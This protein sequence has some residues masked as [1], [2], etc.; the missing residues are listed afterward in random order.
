METIASQASLSVESSRQQYC[1]RQ[2]FPSLG[3][4]PHPGIEPGS[5]ALQVYSFLSEPPG[6][7]SYMH[8]SSRP[9]EG[10][11]LNREICPGEEE[12]NG[13]LGGR[14]TIGYKRVRPP[15]PHLLKILSPPQA[16][17]FPIPSIPGSS[18]STYSNLLCQH[19]S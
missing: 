14:N 8:A 16:P 5:P 1:S 11:Y 17:F 9:A 13:V 3:N 4:L 10:L 6:K 12:A 19:H 2:P 18:P 7:P 15:L